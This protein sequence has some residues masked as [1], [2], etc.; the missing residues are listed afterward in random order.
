MLYKF[1]ENIKFQVASLVA[2]IL[3]NTPAMQGTWVPSLGSIPGLGR[4][5]EARLPTLV[6]WPG[7]FHGQ[8][9]LAGY[10]HEVAKSPELYLY[11]SV[12]LQTN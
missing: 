12:K 8:R 1:K 4:S 9:S 3:K 11:T 2:Q 6:F 5:P 10:V 7:E